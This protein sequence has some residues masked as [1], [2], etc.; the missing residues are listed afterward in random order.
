MKYYENLATLENKLA[1][2]LN[3]EG[4]V[5]TFKTSQYPI[6]LTVSR[7]VSPSAQM[8]FYS[9]NDGASSA[10]AKLQFIFKLDALEIRT[11]NRLEI[12]DALMTKIKGLAKKI[13][14]AFLEGF[15]AEHIADGQCSAPAPVAPT[16]T[17]PPAD[18]VDEFAEFFDDY[19]DND[20]NGNTE[21]DE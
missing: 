21:S 2:I 4:M 8:A 9:M 19:T 18:E 5:F 1:K 3:D 6:T 7:D 17:A 10:D 13:H 16:Y 14:H 12:P 20:D 11:E 15:F